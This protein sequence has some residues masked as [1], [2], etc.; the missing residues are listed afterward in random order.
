MTDGGHLAYL[1]PQIESILG[2]P[3]QAFLDDPELWPSLTHPE[4]R[5]KTVTALADHWT[6]GL[7][8][9]IDYR[10]IAADGSI[11]WVHDEAYAMRD[12]STGGR[13]VSQGLL[14]DTTEQKRLEAQLLHDAF[15][16]PLT[17][18]ANRAL[19]REHLDRTLERARRRRTA[20]AVLFLDI[21]DF[22]VVNDSLGHGAG[23]RLLVE[24]ARS[25]VGRSCG[26][27]TSRRDRVATSSRC[28][29][30]RV[31]DEERGRRDGRAAGGRA[32]PAD[33]ARWT[34][35]RRRASASGSPSR[36]GKDIV[37]GDL[38]AHADAAMY[39][40][41]ERRQGPA[42][43]VRS[44]DAAARAE[45]PRDGGRAARRDRAPRQFELH[46]QPIVELPSRG[47][48]GFEALVRWRHPDRGLVPPGEFIPLAEATGLIVPL[49]R[50]VMTE[51]C[52]QLRAWR[53][54]GANLAHLTVSRERVGPAGRANPGSPR[55]SARSC[56][57]RD[58]S[59]RRS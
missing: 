15:H 16:D 39:A 35:A 28:C 37:A 29:I 23:D 59:R 43:R 21:D 8:L 3:P 49:G 17:G 44:V 41:K 4:D 26:P 52:R 10:M 34:A 53:D 24:V 42:R 9:R 13:R 22:K 5:A 45:P 31:R 51:A 55:R 20:V 14:V 33:R 47:I 36:A 25:P 6:T 46:Y 2:Y 58:S 1:S 38:L 12:E 40:A 11:V 56:A 18:L 54:D 30:E 32:P 27:V 7:P 57:R 48:V 50:L 19:F